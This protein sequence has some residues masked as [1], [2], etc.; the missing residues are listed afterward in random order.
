[1]VVVTLKLSPRP[2]SLDGKIQKTLG[3]IS[4]EIIKAKKIV[5]VIGAGI[6]CSAGIP[7]GSPYLPVVILTSS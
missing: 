1:M 2:T 5:I 3:K 4:K 6:S 7:V